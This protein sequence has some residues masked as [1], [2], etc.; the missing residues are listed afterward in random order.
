MKKT[1][2]KIMSVIIAVMIAASCA[3]VA[4]ADSESYTYVC[5]KCGETVEVTGSFDL[6]DMFCD[7]N[8]TYCDICGE[9]FYGGSV[10][11]ALH[12]TMCA[13]IQI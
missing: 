7:G 4:F 8:G 11:F 2:T 3:S 13:T 9:I 1:L 12:K 5:T 6:H 10:E